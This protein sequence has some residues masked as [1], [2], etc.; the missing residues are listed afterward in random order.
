MGEDGELRLVVDV[1]SGFGKSKM[2]VV[3]FW[4]LFRRVCWI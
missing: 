1:E 4:D 2:D 3:L